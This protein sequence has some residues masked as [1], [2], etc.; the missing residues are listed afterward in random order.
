[1]GE[2]QLAPWNPSR[3]GDGDWPY[4]HS[5]CDRL[6]VILGKLIANRGGG[7]G[8]G[9]GTNGLGHVLLGCVSWGFGFGL[10]VIGDALTLQISH[11]T[12]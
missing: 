5:T 9:L 3:L 8:Y 12:L 4:S 10:V 7:S 11:F 1:L 2:G 6:E